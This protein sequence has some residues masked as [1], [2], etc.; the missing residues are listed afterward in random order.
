MISLSQFLLEAEDQQ[1]GALPIS[2]NL[3][4]CLLDICDPVLA[5][6]FLVCL[7]MNRAKEHLK[8]DGFEKAYVFV[9]RE[10]QGARRFYARHG[11]SW[12]GTHQDIPFPHD[13]VCVDLRYTTTL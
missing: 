6:A 9:L 11:F 1:V 12:D 7:L 5:L 10:N 2:G 3:A 8:A 4:A 13:T